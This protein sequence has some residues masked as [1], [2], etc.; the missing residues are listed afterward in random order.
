[1]ALS[2]TQ[3]FASKQVNNAAP[4][5]LFT[6]GAVPSSNTLRNCRVRFVNTTAV[7]ATIKAWG[8]PAAGAAADGNVIYPLTS[9]G[10]NLSVDVDVSVLS[11][12]GFVQAQAG[13]ANSITAS[14]LD[15]FIQS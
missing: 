10:P 3:L 5:T 8:V 7:A 15:G 12:G 1:M 14:V 2:F 4:D 9:I 6:V 11:A 13:T